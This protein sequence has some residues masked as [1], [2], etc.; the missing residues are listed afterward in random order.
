V[1]EET[2]APETEN[3]MRLPGPVAR[4]E[5][6]PLAVPDA[7]RTDLDGLVDTVIV[8]VHDAEGRCGLAETDAPP[9]LVKAFVESPTAHGWSR[10]V[11][12]L[13]LGADPV[14]TAANWQRLYDGTFWHGRR[15]LGLHAI[16][17]LDVAM[18]DLAGKQ[19]GLPV[20]KMLGGA[21]RAELMPYCT[22]YPGLAH[23]RTVAELMGEIG[24]Q[25]EAALAEG[26]RAVKMEVLFYDLVTDAELVGL[27][28]EGRRMLGDGTVMGVDFGYRWTHWQDA[29]RVLDR[30]ADCDI[31]FAEA[32]L[33]HEDLE[34][35]ARLAAVSPIRV[36][37]AEAAAGRHEVREWIERGRVDVVQPNITRSGGL[38]EM[39]RIAEMAE[40][41][42]VEVIPH[43]W[44][45]G[46]TAAAGMHYQAACPSVPLLEYVSPAVYPSLIRRELTSPE[47]R[48]IDGRLALPDRP[49]L[50]IELNEELVERL[51]TD[52][53][54][55]A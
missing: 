28:R 36:G 29:R 46:I 1:Q 40:M 53:A 44:K 32:A 23:G 24:R 8:R 22:I 54:Q 50:G 43:G 16:G 38:T 55:T 49:G 6:I 21:R 20:Y 39:R 26:F 47:P 30:I 25:F 37:G 33:Q 10:S 17:A 52:R 42:G 19:L 48:V 12:E 7:D 34:G 14:E 35:H 51:R 18:H 41:H 5:A 45:T 9:G 27:I 3:L 31:R 11:S 15:G 13:L 2:L 4:I